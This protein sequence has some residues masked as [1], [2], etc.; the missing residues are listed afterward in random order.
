MATLGEKT[1]ENSKKSFTY[2]EKSFEIEGA[3]AHPVAVQNMFFAAGNLLKKDLITKDEYIALYQKVT[4]YAENGEKHPG[5]RTGP[6]VY[7]DV[8]DRVVA[9]FFDSGVAD[10]ETLNQ[11]LSKQY[12][13]GKE[14][15]DNLKKIASLLRRSECTDLPL[16]ASVAE[17]LYKIDPS[18]EAAYSL[19]MMFMKRQEFDK[20]ISYLQEAIDKSEDDIQKAD[21]YVRMADVKL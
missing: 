5:P 11:L 12:E 19:S 17:Q 7:K 14:D 2:L 20:M 8:K 1:D 16:Y 21:Y 9:M 15:V 3:K 13:A 6:E 10:C 4:A 18:A